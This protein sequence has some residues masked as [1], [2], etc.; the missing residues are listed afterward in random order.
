M[1]Q[2][3]TEVVDLTDDAP[4]K[5]VVSPPLAVTMKLTTKAPTPT[6]IAAKIDADS[7]MPPAAQTEPPKPAHQRTAMLTPPITP[8]KKRSRP[9]D[10]SST[11]NSPNARPVFKKPRIPSDSITR[12]TLHL[13]RVDGGQHIHARPQKTAILPEST[14]VR[15]PVSSRVGTLSPPPPAGPIPYESTASNA[16]TNTPSLSSRVVSHSD[17]AAARTPWFLVSHGNLGVQTSM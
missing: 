6:K 7:L 14:M 11:S 2:K 12:G 3:G 15:S 4:P 13:E 1:E 9:S 16:S 17:A 10:H 8:K 5:K